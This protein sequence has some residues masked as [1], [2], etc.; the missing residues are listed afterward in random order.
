MSRYDELRSVYLELISEREEIRDKL[1]AGVDVYDHPFGVDVG[2]S[3][4]SY[5]RGVDQALLYSIRHVEDLLNEW[6]VEDN[7]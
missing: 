3:V 6:D 4:E 5:Y 1:K 2:P 7:Q